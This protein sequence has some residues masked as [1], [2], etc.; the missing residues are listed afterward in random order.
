V[1]AAAGRDPRRLTELVALGADRTVT[2]AEIATAADADIVLD[3]VWGEPATRA[4]VDVVTSRADRSA[5][6]TWIEVG[7]VAGSD[8][9]I[10]AAALRAAR[11][12][13]VGS[14]I[15]SVP[16]RDFVAELP[17]LAAAVAEGAFDVR[18]RAVPLSDVEHAWTA[19]A[20]DSDRIV[21]VP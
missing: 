6:L 3:Y 4:M 18:A 7:A 20:D 5:S 8:A 15:G 17:E 1:G 14:G 11:L 10:P 19:T 12:Q 13:I 16:G 2:F 9:T 21:L